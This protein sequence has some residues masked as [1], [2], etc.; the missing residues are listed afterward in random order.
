MRAAVALRD[1]VGERQHVLVVAVVPPQRDF[2]ADAVTLAPD[3]DRFLDQ[4]GLGAVEIAHERLKPAFVVQLLAPGLG[5]AQVGQHDA[6][7]RIEKGEL[8]Q[9][10]LDGRI[11]EFDHAEGFGRGRECDLG[12]AL[13]PAVVE[14]RGPRDLE[15]RDS[16]AAREFDKV[17]ES[18][19]PD[20][21]HE[22]RRKRIDH[23]NAN[24][25][26]AT[27]DLVGVLVEFPARVQLGHDDLRGR[28]ALL[29]V[30]PGR[31]AA[32]VVGDGARAV[33]VEGHGDALR[34]A[35]QRLVDGVVDHLIDH[36]V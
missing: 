12:A 34:V 18:V 31:N 1:V 27:R 3:E 7:A 35:G 13:R 33:G 28:H 26:Q 17:L 16:V 30:D 19:A 22:P 10:V 8:A 24:A 20:A 2:D 11:V 21:Q 5:V 9:A 36:V 6:H 4:R 14:R 29:V 15:R 23:R 32:P 25:V